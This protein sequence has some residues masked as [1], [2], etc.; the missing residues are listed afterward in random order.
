MKIGKHL[1]SISI[2]LIFIAG[3]LL[4]FPA[5]GQKAEKVENKVEVYKIGAILP[6]SGTQAYF[7]DESKA[8]LE[9]AAKELKQGLKEKGIEIKVIYED[10]ANDP[11]QTA[12]AANKLINT[13]NIKY[14]ISL[15]PMSPVV[16]S[17][18][19]NR[20]DVLHLAATMSP[21]TVI[22][23]KTM[24][25]YPS[26]SE[27]AR[28]M[29]DF[30]K[31]IGAKR[32]AV[33]HLRIKDH[34]AVVEQI[35]SNLEKAGVPLITET[36]EFTDADAKA[37]MQKIK[38]FKP[39]L[40]MLILLPD[41]HYRVF[42]A[43]NDIAG[44]PKNTRIIGN[45]SF[46]YPTK[47]T[48]KEWLENVC[49]LAPKAFIGGL[50]LPNK[51][52]EDFKKE[53]KMDPTIVSTFLYINMKIL[54]KALLNGKNSTRDIFDFL[55]TTKQFNTAAGEIEILPD[56]DCTVSLGYGVIKDGKRLAFTLEH[57]QPKD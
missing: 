7:G 20:N 35:K 3:T 39:D 16:N 10:S 51:F 2:L 44:L 49:F 34:E 38:N 47:E 40:L 6:L 37:Q 12:V 27:E 21:D 11:A 45:I 15:F 1:F 24:R 19:Q 13:E 36:M 46:L 28:K 9:L 31:S 25:I 43:I 29:M 55:T 5:C 48:P 18:V 26:Q 53:S 8:G 32:V 54:G 4:L 41:F 52:Q 56:G 14:I 22:P 42:K 57:P 30:M 23:G 17:I 50:N 33:F